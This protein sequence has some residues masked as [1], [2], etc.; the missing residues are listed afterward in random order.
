M[1]ERGKIVVE[2][3]TGRRAM[4]IDVSGNDEITCRFS[5]GRLEQRYAFEVEPPRPLLESFVSFVLSLV[6]SPRDGVSRAVGER[7]RPMLV[8]PPGAA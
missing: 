4:V 7:A 3:L 1:P 2:R 6:T 5:D 8:R